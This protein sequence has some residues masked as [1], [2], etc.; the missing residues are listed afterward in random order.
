MQLL[1]GTELIATTLKVYLAFLILITNRITSSNSFSRP[2][3][4]LSVY[5][6]SG[7]VHSIFQLQVSIAPV[8]RRIPTVNLSW[9]LSDGATEY[10]SESAVH[11]LSSNPLF[12]ANTPGISDK[13]CFAD[14]CNSNMVLLIYGV[15]FLIT[16]RNDEDAHS[17][18]FAIH[19]KKTPPY[20]GL[21][22]P[23]GE[24]VVQAVRV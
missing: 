2:C 9:R 4:C 15:V 14:D 7:D 12:N 17:S 11:I 8:V 19:K 1:P 20:G 23:K 6:L 5:L 16:P 21:A 3:Y 10:I 22:K 13:S 24:A 18:H